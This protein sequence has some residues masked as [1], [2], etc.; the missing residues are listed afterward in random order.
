MVLITDPEIKIAISLPGRLV[1]KWE[2]TIKIRSWLYA[3]L[4][5][6]LSGTSVIYMS[7]SV[8][9]GWSRYAL[10]VY[11]DSDRTRIDNYL[12]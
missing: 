12:M 9:L 4:T 8:K 3:H 1:L 11:F 5:Y 6:L 7:I 10:F 2:D